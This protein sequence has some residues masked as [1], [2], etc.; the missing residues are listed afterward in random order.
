MSLIVLVHN[1][2]RK[3]GRP[4]CLPAQRSELRRGLEAPWPWRD[5][6]GLEG[7]LSGLEASWRG[8]RRPRMGWVSKGAGRAS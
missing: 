5:L 7:A 3:G 4:G 8:L 1:S 2:W 6:S